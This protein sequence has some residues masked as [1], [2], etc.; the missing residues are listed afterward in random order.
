MKKVLFINSRAPFPVYDGATISTHQYLILFHELGFEVDLYYISETEDEKVVREG[1]GHLCRNIYHHQVT[2]RQAYRKVLIG[3]LTNLLP[4]QV[5]YYYAR[6]VKKWVDTHYQEYDMIYCHT[7]RTAE[8]VIGLPKYKI[9]NM[10]DS[11]AMNYEKARHLRKGIWH[12]IYTIDAV[13]CAKY[14]KK[15]LDEFDKKLI[16]SEVDREYIMGLSPKASEISVIE[17][18]TEVQDDKLVDNNP[19]VHNLV[20]VGAMNYEPNVTAV[21]HFCNYV[22]PK[23][24]E[25]IPDVKFYIVGKT[26]TEEVLA[27]ASEH[28]VVTGF[29]DDVWDYQKIASVIVAPMK[30]G[31]GMQ[32]KIVQAMAVG[33][34]VMTTP[35]GFGGLVNGEGQPIVV[36]TDAEMVNQLVHLLNHPEERKKIGELSKTY[37]KRN[38]SKEV[39]TRK[40]KA[41]LDA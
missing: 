1:V 4:F 5:N 38:Y 41:F 29:V 32:N 18:Y 19:N 15:L 8:Y 3:M 26:P 25:H 35:D 33:A 9:I 11:F 6:T 21:I 34:C 23:V 31:A 37:I 36:E 16:I 7:L 30:S 24:I 22:L 20:F 12:W 13:R 27:L 39:I 14:E 2:K 17:N 40:F 28:V 10:V